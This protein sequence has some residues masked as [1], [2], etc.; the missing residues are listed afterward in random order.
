MRIILFLFLLL[1]FIQACVPTYIDRVKVKTTSSESKASQIIHIKNLFILAKGNISTRVV[2]TN[3]HSAIQNI[4][5]KNGSKSEFEF[6]SVFR[7]MQKTDITTT[8]NS[9]DGYMLLSPRYTA[10]ID[11]YQDKLVFAA[12][13]SSTGRVSGTGYGNAYEDIFLIELF[14]SKKELIYTG[15][16]NFHFDPTK[17][18]LYKIAADR[19]VN[20]LAK[21]NIQLW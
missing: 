1:S 12:P 17:D 21:S 8:P 15:E 20:Q 2:S 7:N 19:V 3:F 9:Y 5:K 10:S 13:T 16:I 18:A 6:K 4:M 11:Y 14:N